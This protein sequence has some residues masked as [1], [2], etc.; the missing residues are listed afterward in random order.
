M[1]AEGDEAE[2]DILRCEFAPGD[3]GIAN[4]ADLVACGVDV[5]LLAPCSVLEEHDI[6]ESNLRLAL[7]SF[8]ATK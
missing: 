3:K 6:P 8:H 7:C 2:S 5:W 1:V 4:L